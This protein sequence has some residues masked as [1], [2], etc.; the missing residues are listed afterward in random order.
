VSDLTRNPQGTFTG[1]GNSD[2]VLSVLNAATVGAAY[3]FFEG[4][5]LVGAAAVA[6]V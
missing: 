2:R 5:L 3:G 6:G 4:S 1:N